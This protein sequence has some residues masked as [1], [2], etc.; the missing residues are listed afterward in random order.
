MSSF[1]KFCLVGVINTVTDVTIFT[2]LHTAGMA[3]LIANIISTSVALIIS[4]ILNRRF[5][6]PTD[7]VSHGR[8]ALYIVVTLGGLWILAPLTIKALMNLDWHIGYSQPF[9][10]LFGHPEVMQTLLPKIGSVA[11]TL[12]WNYVWYSRVVFVEPKSRLA[13]NDTDR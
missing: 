13:D 6:F 7:K 5:T 11:V 1:V 10:A 3:L 8:M 9:I 4:F 2:A 12:A